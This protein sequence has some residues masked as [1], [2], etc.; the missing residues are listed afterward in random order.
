MELTEGQTR[1]A[2]ASKDVEQPR[3]GA[4]RFVACSECPNS[5]RRGPS[6][7]STIS[8]QEGM[9]VTRARA[10]VYRRRAQECFDLARKISLET[11]RAVIVDIAQTWLRLA[12]QQEMLHAQ[13]TEQPQQQEQTQPKDDDK[14][15]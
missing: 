5:E 6:S 4:R 12:E 8:D 10:E 15:E 14:K 2:L 1:I 9:A 11:E 7:V 3:T 13:L